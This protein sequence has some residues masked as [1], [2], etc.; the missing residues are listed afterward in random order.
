MNDLSIMPHT[1]NT[2]V[3]DGASFLPQGGAGGWWRPSGL[4]AALLAALPELRPA[5]LRPFKAQVRRN[6]HTVTL[7][8]NFKVQKPGESP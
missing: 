2:R 6:C 3:A 1:S 4:F 7:Q 5:L 8:E